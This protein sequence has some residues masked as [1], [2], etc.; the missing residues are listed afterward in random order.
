[1]IKAYFNVETMPLLTRNFVFVLILVYLVVGLVSFV[2]LLRHHYIASNQNKV[3]QN[4]ILES[5]L[6]LKQKELNYLKQQIHPHFL[7]NTLNTI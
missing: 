3:L 4:K 6:L 7:F 1:M 5:K 2:G